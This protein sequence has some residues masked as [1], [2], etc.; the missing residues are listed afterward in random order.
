M[1]SSA[2]PNDRLLPL[3]ALRAAAYD[4]LR[5]T[6]WEEPSPDYIALV[7]VPGYL[8]SFPFADEQ[9]DIRQGIAT[10]AAFLRWYGATTGS[11]LDELHSEFT[12]LFI[13]PDRLPAP[14]WE[15]AYLAEDRLILQEPVLQVRA[16]YSRYQ[17]TAKNSWQKIDDHLGLELDFMYQLA[18]L[19]R[20]QRQDP[21]QFSAVLQDSQSFLT[22]HL[23]SWVPELCRDIDASDR[24]GFYRGMSW[25]LKGFLTV[26]QAALTEILT[27]PFPA[28]AE[29]PR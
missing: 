27:G 10:T 16:A 17:F 12:R 9:P 5:R 21:T 24:T 3:L 26:D 20:E 2:M 28:E 8:D 15:S 4:L 11:C 7:S 1:Q 14:P 23:L 22:E 19:C 6:F 29:N 25:M 13:G 18:G